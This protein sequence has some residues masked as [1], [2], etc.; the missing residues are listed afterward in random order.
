MKEAVSSRE[1]KK[2]KRIAIAFVSLLILVLAIAAFSYF[3]KL[4]FK[5]DSDE[6]VFI[7]SVKEDRLIYNGEEYI[8]NKNV[9]S[10]LV[11]GVDKYE[12]AASS[13]VRNSERSDFLM[14]L[15]FDK[16]EGS[17][18]ALHI[19]RD[20]MANV[21]ELGVKGDFADYKQMQLALAHTYGDGGK[22]SAVNTLEA[23]E[24]LLYGINIDHYIVFK[25]DAVG[26]VADRLGGLVIS[27]PLSWE[28]PE[29]VKDFVAEENGTLKLF[30][31][32]AL[33]FVRF[34]DKENA[35][36]NLERM[37]RQRAFISAVKKQSKEILLEDESFA[38]D[39]L[40]EL[41]SYILTDVDI[42]T[43]DRYIDI[44]STAP[45]SEILNIGGETVAGE[46]FIE[47]YCDADDVKQKLLEL[48]YN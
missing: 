47:Y 29:T 34:R 46:K 42:N 6:E 15:S 14:L 40:L 24:N 39:T 26:I 44:L 7:P 36:G 20:T 32:A 10:I 9:E 2:K 27:D 28:A 13:L 25:M 18:K 12:E 11:I 35:E 17:Y 4:E 31:P 38:A 37:E 19:N 21:K 48:F 33:S 30:G 41:S 1:K 16:K 45:D 23:V 8:R 3:E 5:A 22:L 43:L